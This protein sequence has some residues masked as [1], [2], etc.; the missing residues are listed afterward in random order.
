VTLS[1]AWLI[2]VPAGLAAYLGYLTVTHDAPLAPF[3]AVDIYWGRSFAGPFGAVVRALGALPGDLTRL[4]TGTA[5]PFGVGDPLTWESH[6]LIDLAFV[7]VAFGALIAC[8]R[9]IPFAYFAYVA[10]MLVFAL[11]FPR[12]IEPLASAPRYLLGMFP[13]FIGAASWLAMR[14]RWATAVL[15]LSAVLLALF[16]GLWG[17]WAWVA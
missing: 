15:G 11:S 1:A 4:F 2:L 12:E 16:S 7:A 9:R 3:Q 6:D 14:G 5:T 17:M 10:V 8:W 13:L